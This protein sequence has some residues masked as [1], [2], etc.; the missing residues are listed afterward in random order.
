MPTCSALWAAANV[1]AVYVC[2]L[3][4]QHNGGNIAGTKV[5]A[6]EGDSDQ[7]EVEVAI[8]P[9]GNTVPH[10]GA[11][12]VELLCGGEGWREGERKE[13]EEMR[14]GGREGEREG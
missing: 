14:E 11:V 8:V 13:G 6:C 4:T 10:P 7:E 3:L 9:L 1:C 12:V 2:E 5:Q